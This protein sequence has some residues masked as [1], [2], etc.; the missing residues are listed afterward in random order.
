MGAPPCRAAPPPQRCLRG[1]RCCRGG[2]TQ[3]PTRSGRMDPPPHPGPS[4]TPH[5]TRQGWGGPWVPAPQ[6]G[7]NLPWGGGGGHPP[8]NPPN[9]PLHPAGPF[10]PPSELFSHQTGPKPAPGWGSHEGGTFRGWGHRPRHC[11]PPPPRSPGWPCQGAA[12]P[13]PHTH[14]ATRFAPQPASVPP[15][16]TP[17]RHQNGDK[18]AK[19]GDRGTW[20]RTRGDTMAP[21]PQRPKVGCA[22]APP[23]K[24][25]PPGTP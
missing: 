15:P 14:T 6:S 11:H 21:D 24:A 19:F 17:S 13:P 8:P 22:G 4:R 20:G 9:S 3:T 16:P 12:G 5:P 18:P 23:A 1:A 10:T 2:G 7:S 25:V